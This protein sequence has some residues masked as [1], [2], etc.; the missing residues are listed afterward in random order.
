MKILRS[1]WVVACLLLA[2]ASHASPSDLDTIYV[3]RRGWHIDIGFAVAE[4]VAPLG[5]VS[6][7][8]PGSRYLLFGFG[9][10]RYL[11]AKH[12][13]VPAMLGAVWPGQGLILV[14]APPAPPVALLRSPEVAVPP[15]PEVETNA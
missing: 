4:L 2:P 5:A 10:R 9:D 8:F 15:L 7:E 3:V 12:S 14:T 6:G 11:M 1:L 13:H